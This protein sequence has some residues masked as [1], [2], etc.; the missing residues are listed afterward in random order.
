MTKL[1][2]ANFSR[3]L[4][5][6]I[7]WIV[8]SVMFILAVFMAIKNGLTADSY[9]DVKSLNSCYFTILPMVGFFY[10]VFI[11]FYI[12]TD[13]ND[14]T[15]RNKLIVGHN[16]LNIYFS[17]YITCFTGTFVIIVLLVI[18]SAFSAPF[19]G[20]WEGGIKSYLIMAFLCIFITAALTAIITM[21]SMLSSNKAITVV[22]TIVV[23]LGLIIMASTIY[24]Q[25]AEAEFT[26]EFISLSADGTVELGPEISNPAYVSGWQR[27][28]YEWLLQFLPTGQ[29]VLIANGEIT[30]PLINII[31]SVVFIIAVNV[32]GV[33][34]FR[35]KDLK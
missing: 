27:K 29:S 14:G 31:Y 34:A 22:L 18:G 33:L 12:G 1:L 9:D 6:K 5:D 23:S 26:R 2:S 3:L 24:N 21:V 28:F 16:R 19:L 25:L 17:N 20:Y 35:K 13:Y 30:D 7:F 8:S 32:C 15:I 11:S 10:S 4:R